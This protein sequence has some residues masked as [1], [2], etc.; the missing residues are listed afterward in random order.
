MI[1]PRLDVEDVGHVSLLRG[2]KK[3]RSCTV[4][5]PLSQRS[6]NDQPALS[7]RSIPNLDR[8]ALELL[9]F[10][11]TTFGAYMYTLYTIEAWAVIKESCV[12]PERRADF[13][14][15]LQSFRF[16]RVVAWRKSS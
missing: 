13:R 8:I 10:N 2:D 7:T 12:L 6:A 5:E 11:I 14:P 4:V 1:P 9:L 16:R 15:I 3:R